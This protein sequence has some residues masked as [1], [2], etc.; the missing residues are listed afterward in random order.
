MGTAM[1]VF[2]EIFVAVVGLVLLVTALSVRAA[3]GKSLNLDV[4][5]E[6]QNG[7]ALFQIV[8]KG[9]RW[10]DSAML[11]IYRAVDRT[12]LNR[13]RLRMAKD[14]QASFR[15]SKGTRP[16]DQLAIYIDPNWYKREFRFDGLVSCR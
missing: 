10:P 8:N 12:L 14:Q 6:C 7:V 5:A 9:D 13:R 1:T 2:R 11:N 3:D 15:V 4:N 16:G